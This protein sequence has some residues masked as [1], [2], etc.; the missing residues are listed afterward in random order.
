MISGDGAAGDDELED[1]VGAGASE[2]WGTITPG[3]AVGSVT[4]R[5]LNVCGARVVVFVVV[6]VVVT[7]NELEDDVIVTTAGT[8]LTFGIPRMLSA[9]FMSKQ[10]TYTP[11]VPFIGTAKHEFPGAQLVSL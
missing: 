2:V 4:E 9:V 7:A 8:L 10:P 5:L 1:D 3:D 6:E 11:A